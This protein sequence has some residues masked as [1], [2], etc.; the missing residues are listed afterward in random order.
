[1]VTK[2]KFSNSVIFRK[3]LLENSEIL[4]FHLTSK[5]VKGKAFMKNC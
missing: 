3:Q 5:D 4:R 1:M 2:R